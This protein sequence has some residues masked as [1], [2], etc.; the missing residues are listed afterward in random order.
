MY[1]ILGLR[2]L[3]RGKHQ[4]SNR[5][6]YAISTTSVATELTSCKHHSTNLIKNQSEILDE[7][8]IAIKTIE[9]PGTPKNN[10]QKKSNGNSKIVSKKKRSKKVTRIAFVIS[11]CF[12]LSYLPYV[13][14]KLNASVV[15]GQFTETPLTKAIF[16]I[17]AR[18]FIINNIINPVIYGFLDPTFLKHC[19]MTIK[20]ILC[21]K[22]QNYSL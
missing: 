9:T 21:M 15:K 12:I 17:L 18:T 13:A 22:S 14:V 20:Y 7:K 2:L 11:F 16:P 4:N 5:T 6:R 8:S 3:E 19:K 1:S 10:D